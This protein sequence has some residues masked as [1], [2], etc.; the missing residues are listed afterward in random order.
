MSSLQSR[1][2]PGTLAG[3]GPFSAVTFHPWRQAGQGCREGPSQVP[4]GT[5]QV[6]HLGWRPQSTMSLSPSLDPGIMHVLG[7]RSQSLGDP[8]L[9]WVEAASP[10]EEENNLPTP[11]WGP[12]LSFVLAVANYTAALVVRVSGPPP[13][14]LCPWLVL[15]HPPGVSSRLT[16]SDPSLGPAPPARSRSPLLSLLVFSGSLRV[17]LLGCLLSVC[18]GHVTLHEGRLLVCLVHNHISLT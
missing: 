13:S 14:L 11:G 1:P 3:R 5:P 15:S 10:W 2:L 18:P 6:G 8:P 17:C 9:P 7:Q 16:S 12:A 4:D